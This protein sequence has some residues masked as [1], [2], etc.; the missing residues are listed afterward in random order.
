MKTHVMRKLPAD[1]VEQV[2]WLFEHAKFIMREDASRKCA[3][4]MELHF[5][6]VLTMRRMAKKLA[7]DGYSVMMQDSLESIQIEGGIRTVRDLGPTA[8]IFKVGA[9]KPSGVRKFVREILALAETYG[10]KCSDLTRMTLSDMR[11]FMG[12][13]SLIRTFPEARIRLYHYTDSGLAAGAP[14][15]FVFGFH[16]PNPAATIAGLK[17]AGIKSVRRGP[18]QVEWN[19]EARLTR[20]NDIDVLEAE[21][22]IARAQAKALKCKLMGVEFEEP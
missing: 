2:D 22:K 10:A 13:P 18:R 20:S 6:S 7:N 19:V 4:Q 1:Y 14:L 15:I 3:W 5:P 8:R 12:P 21:F 16:A 17:K 9:L 11:M